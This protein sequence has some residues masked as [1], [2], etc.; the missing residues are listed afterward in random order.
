MS[1]SNRP[2]VVIVGAGLGGIWAAKAIASSPVDVLLI[3]RNNYHTFLALLYQVAAAELEPENIVYPIRDILR[4]IPN[5]SFLLAKVETVD[6]TRKI[7]NTDRKDVPYDFLILAAGS[8]PHFFG[9]PGTKEYAFP[10]KTMDEGIALR[11]HILG[12][13]ER[14]AH[15]P[16]EQRKRQALTFVVVGGGATGVEFSGALSELVYGLLRKDYPALAESKAKVIL[17][18]AA[19]TLLASLPEKCRNY[20]AEQLKKVGVD[21]RF[22]SCVSKVTKDAVHLKD[23]TVIP[24]ETVVWTAGVRGNSMVWKMKLPTTHDSRVRILPTLQVS[25]CPEVYVV[26]DMAYLEENGRPLPMVAQV[27]LQQGTAAAQNIIRQME[28]QP[29]LPFRYNDLGSMAT[30]GRHSV[31]ARLNGRAFTGLFAWLLWLIVHLVR[32][33]GFRNRLLVLINWTWNYFLY[34][35]AVRLIM[36]GEAASICKET[37]S[38]TAE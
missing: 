20:T 36:P 13:F 23:G 18:E 8:E 2:K 4:K 7:V 28:G 25:E 31:V 34:E 6:F 37:I 1:N 19:D 12:L 5:T 21:V 3:D 24:S 29:L 26:G 38:V 15:E 17:L 30:I 22:K 9:V 33:V 27:A 32:L 35:R 16:D 14:A 11:N 10:L